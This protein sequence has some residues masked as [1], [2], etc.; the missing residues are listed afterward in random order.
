MYIG[1]WE[2]TSYSPLF[3]LAL[4]SQQGV[5]VSKRI[6]LILLNPS[7]HVILLDAIPSLPKT[8]RIL[9]R[10]YMTPLAYF[11]FSLIPLYSHQMIDHMNTTFIPLIEHLPIFGILISMI[12][13]ISKGIAIIVSILIIFTHIYI[14]YISKRIDR[15]SNEGGDRIKNPHTKKINDTWAFKTCLLTIIPFHNDGIVYHKFSFPSDFKLMIDIS[16]CLTNKFL[17]F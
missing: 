12:F 14:Y 13:M 1:M 3:T 11:Y 9:L 5:V 4:R 7:K 17:L 6:L 15:F 16:N 2:N 8:I 10:V